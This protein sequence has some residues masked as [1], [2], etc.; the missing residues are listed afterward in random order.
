MKGNF[1]LVLRWCSV[2]VCGRSHWGWWRVFWCFCV[3]V[4][5]GWVLSSLQ[6]VCE[7]TCVSPAGVLVWCWDQNNEP[8]T[9]TRLK[10]A[11]DCHPPFP[12]YTHRDDMTVSVHLNKTHAHDAKLLWVFAVMFHVC[13]YSGCDGVVWGLWMV[14]VVV[15]LL[16]QWQ[17]SS[18]YSSER[19]S[20]NITTI[21]RFMVLIRI[22]FSSRANITQRCRVKVC[23]I[24]HS[25]VCL[26][27]RACGG[28]ER[29]F[30]RKSETRMNHLFTFSKSDAIF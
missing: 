13:F 4:R 26:A 24:K 17:C 8:H 6:R 5:P 30:Q 9:P 11:P 28:S 27:V 23:F 14:C 12:V 22:S 15:C 3:C 1:V 2:P 21:S 10:S 18:S 20:K 16:Q 29:L 19:S 7:T 25:V